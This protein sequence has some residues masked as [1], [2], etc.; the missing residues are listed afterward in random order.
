MWIKKDEQNSV[1]ETPS[2]SIKGTFW[3]LSCFIYPYFEVICRHLTFA[4]MEKIDILRGCLVIFI[5]LTQEIILSVSSL[6]M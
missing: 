4:K 3:L 1:L 6:I 5:S 2:K